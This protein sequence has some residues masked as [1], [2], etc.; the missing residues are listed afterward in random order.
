MKFK[1]NFLQIAN[2]I[3]ILKSKHLEINTQ[4]IDLID[5]QIRLL[6]LIKDVINRKKYLSGIQK[7]FLK[8]LK[9]VKDELDIKETK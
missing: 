1:F 3:Y 4:S 9:K 6:E 7:D 5:N 2:W 8:N